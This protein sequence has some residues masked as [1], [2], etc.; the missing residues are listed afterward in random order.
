[1]LY[2]YCS[3]ISYIPSF[4]SECVKTMIVCTVVK[5]FPIPRAFKIY[6]DKRQQSKIPSNKPRSMAWLSHEISLDYAD[7]DAMYLYVCSLLFNI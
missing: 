2:Y 5:K 7:L 6:E 1:M 3:Y 4:P